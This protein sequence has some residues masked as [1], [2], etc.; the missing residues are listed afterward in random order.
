MAGKL[1]RGKGSGGVSCQ[2]AEREPAV[3]PGGKKGQWHSGLCQKYCN[4]QKQGGDCPSGRS[5]GEAASQTLCSRQTSRPW[6]KSREG[7]RAVQGLEHISVLWGVTEGTV[8]DHS[9]EEEAQ[10]RQFS[11]EAQ[12]AN[13]ILGSIMR[14][15]A[16]MDREE[17]STLPL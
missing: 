12:K 13:G 6:S 2:L 5:S 14:G 10:G 8:I 7:N 3:C 16:S 11:S 1:H 9:E 15:V 17:I 4:Q